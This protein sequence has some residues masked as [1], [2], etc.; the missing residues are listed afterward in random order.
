MESGECRRKERAADPGAGAAGM[1]PLA[2][3]WTSQQ[4]RMRTM[5]KRLVIA[6]PAIALLIASPAT[7]QK[8][9]AGATMIDGKEEL[10]T[11][12]AALGTIAIVEEKQPGTEAEL[13]PNL[14]AFMALAQQQEGVR[15]V[16]PL[17]LLKMLIARSRCFDIVE[18]GEGFTALQREREI[19]AGGTGAPTPALQSAQYLLTAQTV[20]ANANSGGGGGGL[21]GFG[22]AIGGAFGLKSKTLET[23]ILLT[24]VEVKTGIQRGTASGSARKKDLKFIGGGLAGTIGALGGGYENT[25]MGKLTAA[26]LLDAYR[27]LLPQVEGL[28]PPTAVAASPAPVSAAVPAPVSTV[29]SATTPTVATPAT[30]LPV[31]ASPASAEGSAVSEPEPRPQ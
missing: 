27:K 24:L 31:P 7:A 16:S 15:P 9:G 2:A 18:R 10:A 30:A 28:A 6:M 22:G 11:C 29:G 12:A 23:Q 20:Y 21:G 17:P 25:D 13:P 4:E 3:A 14:R 5:F 19:A 8:L 1:T 26:A